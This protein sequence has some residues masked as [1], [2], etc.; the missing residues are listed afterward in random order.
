MA[1]RDLRSARAGAAR[2]GSLGSAAI[3]GGFV[4]DMSAAPGFQ[5]PAFTGMI[6]TYGNALGAPARTKMDVLALLA[7]LRKK[8]D[9]SATNQFGIG[10][11]GDYQPPTT[12]TGISV[13]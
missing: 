3:G 9:Q 8:Y 12:T 7:G 10:A 5:N 6:N 2:I 13:G 11:Y 1:A 4:P